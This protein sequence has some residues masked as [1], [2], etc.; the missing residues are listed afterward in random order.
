MFEE[1]LKNVKS[2]LNQLCNSAKDACKLAEGF[3]KT[4]GNDHPPDPSE[5]TKPKPLYDDMCAQFKLP[6]DYLDESHKI[7]LSAVVAADLEF[8]VTDP[9]ATIMYNYLFDAADPFSEC[10]S[11]KW[12]QTYTNDI[13]FLTTTQ[14][15]VEN[16]QEVIQDNLEGDAESGVE[17]VPPAELESIWAAVKNS[18]TFLET[19]SYMEWSKLEFLNH[20]SFF[21]Q[22]VS[23]ANISAPILALLIPVIMLLV[24]FLLLKIQG[25]AITFNS[26]LMVLQDIAKHHFIGKAI[27]SLKNMNAQNV[28]YF[29]A[30]SGLYFYQIYQNT[31]ACMR[32]YKNVS[33][34]NDSL[35]TVKRHVQASIDHME[36]FA[37]AQAGLKSAPAYSAFYAELV[38]QTDSLKRFARKLE[39][40]QKFRPSIFKIGEVGYL[41]EC[42]YTL[43]QDSAVDAALRFSFGF[44]GYWENVKQ[45]YLK[46]RGGMI[47]RATYL[48][49]PLEIRE[50]GEID[51]SGNQG[52]D[53]VTHTGL[54]IKQQYYPPYVGKDHV[55]NDTLFD[56][57]MIITGPNAAGKTTMIKST[58]INILMS[59]QV[60]F[61]FYGECHIQPYSHIHS[62]LNIPDTSGR[63]SLF[64]A[65]S[66]RC[67]DI[68][69]EVQGDL[70]GRHFCIFDELYSGTNPTEA[71][72]SAGSF[73][74]YL[75]KYENVD[76][77]LTTHYTALCKKM[78]KSNPRV[79]NYK[80]EAEVVDDRLSYTYRLKRG[81][82]YIEGAVYILKD[83]N[84]PEEICGEMS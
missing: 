56:K 68:L 57:N 69:D 7:G 22:A 67:R 11:K 41:L 51:A 32:F 75:S 30:M 5:T 40:I 55:K 23:L 4:L 36:S 27:L 48:T 76:F 39:P 61:G 46:Y 77:I 33:Y 53:V 25:I 54:S 70:V 21:L 20:S 73:L 26:Y 9:S 45:V 52:S 29:V 63:D 50:K 62:Y 82:S 60:G 15:V 84:Y 80:M 59:Q 1:V 24:P 64:Q 65:E 37:R 47:A 16:M 43:H 74:K 18:P 2:E 35:Y 72:K 71:V 66:R 78:R 44:A 79:C 83:M 38:K 81:I 19:Y 42:F 13:T 28:L 31:M 10:I 34:I 6:I 12:H 3:E 8:Q 49:E 17:T 14:S 58:L